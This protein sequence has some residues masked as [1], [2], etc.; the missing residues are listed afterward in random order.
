[1]LCRLKRSLVAL[2]LSHAQGVQRGPRSLLL[3][4][5][6]SCRLTVQQTSGGEAK[7]FE[8]S[9]TWEPLEKPDRTDMIPRL[10]KGFQHWGTKPMCQGFLRTSLLYFD[11]A[12]VK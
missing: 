3:R 8:G 9:F 4:A 2:S 11:L 7:I 5:D 1:M 6:G 10:Q 12:S